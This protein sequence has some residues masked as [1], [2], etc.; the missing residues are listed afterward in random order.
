MNICKFV[1]NGAKTGNTF[2]ASLFIPFDNTTQCI[3]ILR[4]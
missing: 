3:Q 4:I 1:K 2:S